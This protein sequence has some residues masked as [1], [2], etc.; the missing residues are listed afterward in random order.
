M[1]MEQVSPVFGVH[2]GG[3]YSPEVRKGRRE[4]EEGKRSGGRVQDVG[5]QTAGCPTGS[6]AGSLAGCAK[7]SLGPPFSLS[8][9]LMLL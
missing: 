6:D 1:F 4:K 5:H 8:A 2:R 9:S 7:G 3:G